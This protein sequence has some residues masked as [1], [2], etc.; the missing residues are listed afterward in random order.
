[1]A[2]RPHATCHAEQ[3]CRLRPGA[4]Q[5]QHQHAG[6]QGVQMIGQPEP[7]TKNATVTSCSAPAVSWFLWQLPG[8]LFRPHS[9]RQSRRPRPRAPTLGPTCSSGC[10]GRAR[11]AAASISSS[12]AIAALSS[13]SSGRQPDSKVTSDP[14]WASRQWSPGRRGSE[15]RTSSC[16]GGGGGDG[17]GGGQQQRRPAARHST[18]AGRI[19]MD[20][21]DSSQQL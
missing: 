21:R 3:P 19:R 8:K 17:G 12:A 20:Q 4:H 18:A 10:P 7:A 15:T 16:G 14:T 13:T 5:H 11:A 2:P 1:M 9:G 6:A